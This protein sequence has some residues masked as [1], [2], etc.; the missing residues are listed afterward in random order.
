MTGPRE[1]VKDNFLVDYGSFA[2][3]D[4]DG[5]SSMAAA[6]P[7]EQLFAQTS[8]DGPWFAATANMAVAR[9][10]AGYHHIV[11]IT[12]ELWEKEPPVEYEPKAEV[13][14]AEMYSSSGRVR[15]CNS[16]GET[17]PVID[18]GKPDA[19]WSVR[20]YRMDTSN[21]GLDGEFFPDEF[22]EDDEDMGGY[23]EGL[24]E[25]RFRFWPKDGR[26]E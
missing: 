16:G 26:G 1:Y 4:I 6:L 9:S 19:L 5:L 15:A 25:F 21:P 23:P 22:D 18:L 12:L 13:H 17:G 14:T 7:P 20:G 24:E 10:R 11:A 2:I 3:M 8:Q